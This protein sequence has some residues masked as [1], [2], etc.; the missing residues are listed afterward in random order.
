[1]DQTIFRHL[2]NHIETTMAM[3]DDCADQIAD[4]AEKLTTALLAGQTIYSCGLDQTASLSQ[5]FVN[6]LSSGYQI[7]RP[8]F[9]AVDLGAVAN[10]DQQHESFSRPLNILGKFG[11]ILVVFSNGGN[12]PILRKTIDCATEKGIFV[13]LLSAL[14]DNLLS[15]SL[16]QM[17]VEIVIGKYGG[18]FNANMNFL[19]IQCLCKLI[20]IKIFGGD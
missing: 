2:Q 11:D 4:V 9:P 16:G 3:G 15:E 5:F 20:D 12:N 10:H 6:H 14:D 7:E 8:G 1:M 13:I 18:E 19:I 17:D